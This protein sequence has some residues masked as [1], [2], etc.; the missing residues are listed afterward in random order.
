MSASKAML[1]KVLRP[2]RALRTVVR[3]VRQ[4]GGVLAVSAKAWGVYRR[5]GISGLKQGFAAIRTVAANPALVN[6]TDYAE[7]VRRYDTLTDET[8]AALR[9]SLAG[10]P[11]PLISVLMPVYNPDPAW[12]EAAIESVRAQIYTN[13]ELCI[14]DDASTNESVKSLLH[15]YAALDTRIKVVFRETNGHIS[16]AS[17][18]ALELA[19][20]EWITLFDHDDLLTEHALFWI[21]HA[22]AAHPDAKLIYSDEDKVD[23]QGN[24]FEPH[25]KPD[26]NY[27]LFLSYNMISHLGA[28]RTQ[29]V[30]ALGGFR[31][32]FEGAQDYDL[33][34]RCVETLQPR[35]IVHVPRVLYHWRVHKDSTAMAG[36]SKPYALIAGEKA[37]NEHF[38]RTGVDAT[39][40]LQPRG[41]YRTR[42]ALPAQPP[43][44]SLIIPT[45]NGE[46]LVRQCIRSIRDKTEYQNY[47]IILVDNGS[48]NPSALR[49]FDELATT[50]GV[51]V[52]R[53]DRPFNYSALNNNA[54]AHARGEF[55]ALINNDIEVISPGWLGEM[56]SIALQ[57]GV[58]AVGARLLYPSGGLQ[59]GGVILG[60]GGVAGHS[61][62][63][64]PRDHVG[65]FFRAILT[66][67]LSA[68]TAACLVVRKS[69]YEA[70]GGLEEK[71]LTVAFN[72]VDFCVRV[73]EAGYRNVYASYA[74]LYHHESVS[75]GHEDSPEKVARF[76]SEV[77][78]MISRWTEVLSSDP[79]YSP[80][81]TQDFEDF[82]YAWPPRVAPV[83]ESS[84]RNSPSSKQ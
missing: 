28:Y 7:W 63:H 43:L 13:W 38:K 46:D 34:L 15:R 58:G 84:A 35:Q 44:V 83:P 6:R 67:D 22:M 64:F 75:R 71:A 74:E 65:Y 33:A 61:H 48:D 42:Y 1:R 60:L 79:A 70:V 45:R 47:E 54:V 80:N 49:Y 59:H 57:P 37:L 66:Q 11:Q 72:D 5:R 25:F 19:H 36:D 2:V 41:Y 50:D 82:S 17:N 40:A 55:V 51:R 23:E 20:G 12:L 68:V 30:R 62:K 26:W 9:E 69:I 10:L 3:V 32:G 27:A 56:M 29:M 24:R 77:G 4:R 52:I 8:R 73:R 76:Q 21:A 78:Y 81:L 53:D 31:T 14:A 18:S 16:A 39:A